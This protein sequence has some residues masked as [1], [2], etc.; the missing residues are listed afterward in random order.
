MGKGL[1]SPSKPKKQR[2]IIKAFA[3]C[4]RARL[5]AVVSQQQGP[6]LVSASQQRSGKLE[7]HR[8]AEG[9]QAGWQGT[10]PCQDSGDR[11]MWWQLLRG[12]GR[13]H[14]S[15]VEPCTGGGSWEKQSALPAS[16]KRE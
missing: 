5:H 10:Q 2:N 9:R 15:T 3:V 1:D 8:S 6:V 13:E 11:E 14:P 7:E 4:F 12:E 16:T